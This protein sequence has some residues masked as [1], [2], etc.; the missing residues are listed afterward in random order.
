ML[1]R[2]KHCLCARSPKLYIKSTLGSLRM[3]RIVV[4][5]DGTW[6][7]IDKDYPTNVVK[8]AQSILPLD[9][10]G[11]EQIVYYDEG[12]GTKQI[13]GKRSIIDELIKLGGGGLGLGIDHKIQDAYMFLC[14]N[15]LPGDE[16]YL[17]GFSRGAYTVRC[18][19]GLIYNSGLCHRKHMRKIPA[20]YE[21][22]RD[23]TVSRRP[24]GAD[25][26][27]FRNYYGDRVPIN[28]LCCWDTVASLG[29]PDLIPGITLDDTFNERYQF[30]DNRINQTIKHAFHA[31]SIDE[32][33]KVFYY[34]PME[35]ERS[36]QLSQVW[37][38]GGHGCVG[39]G[40][41]EERDLSD[42]PLEW[43]I[44]K[45]AELGLSV[46]T[47]NIEY[48]KVNGET[49]YGLRPV[50]SSPFVLAESRLGYRA[51]EL[52]PTTSFADLDLSVKKRWK[53]PNCRYRPECLELKFGT[54]L[55]TW[56]EEA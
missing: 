55:D 24:G 10:S 5:S 27:S 42:G 7:D 51:R 56:T 52:P 35:S 15:Y 16:I 1:P 39:G 34:T 8:M 46:D 47:N 36:G 53:D 44:K 25:A 19:A 26:V 3:K 23:R 33:R 50:Y 37:F 54:E 49:E 6:Q 28:A 14:L 43:M 40:S 17:F 9:S 13:G 18:L 2:A 11:I 30:Y 45:V 12:I 21:L 20:A 31:V 41:E 38:P 4:C 32:N 48:G 22:Y 29:L